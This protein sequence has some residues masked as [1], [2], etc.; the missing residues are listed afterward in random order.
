MSK[1]IPLPALYLPKDIS[2]NTNL[3]SIPFDTFSP[4]DIN[5][6]Y[7][8][9]GNY[10]ISA[11][12]YFD[13]NTQPYNAFTKETNSYWKCNNI[14]NDYAFNPVI[15]PYT[16]TPY[17]AST[18]QNTPS[19][20]QGGGILSANYY[21]TEVYSI[22][23]G[24]DRP[25]QIY[26][27]WL[28]IQFPK[29]FNLTQYSLLS[30]P[31]QGPLNYFPIEFT[32]AGSEDGIKWYFIDQQ[33]LSSSPDVSKQE[34]IP[35][36]VNTKNSYSYFR[37]I[38]TLMPPKTDIVR[39]SQWNILGLPDNKKIDGDTFIGNRTD[40]YGT[41]NKQFSY[42]DF[43]PSLNNF[44]NFSISEPMTCGNGSASR[45]IYEDNY[46]VIKEESTGGFSEPRSGIEK[47]RS[48][49]D[50]TELRSVKSTE[51]GFE[52]P[53]KSYIIDIDLSIMLII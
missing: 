41:L 16:Q 42:F 30:P 25:Q 19:I 51:D 5:K 32:V 11:S 38:I 21:K 18:V 17:L 31:S 47:P 29:K 26:G 52:K 22:N 28:Q 15:K 27:E 45:I 7:D 39:L 23:S 6:I 14:E 8:I 36:N 49:I 3:F 50:V 48:S 40:N 1:I 44:S 13:K 53:S 37:L 10:K 9:G 2:L 34:P 35:F 4:I 20:Y 33:N 12:S 43:Y 24:I 46:R